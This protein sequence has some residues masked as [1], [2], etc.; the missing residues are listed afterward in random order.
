[1]AV[2]IIEPAILQDFF[3]SI[4]YVELKISSSAF[5]ASR[6]TIFLQHANFFSLI[7]FDYKGHFYHCCTSQNP[8]SHKKFTPLLGNSQTMSFTISG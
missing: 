3:C 5:A 4:N 6:N 1:M 8:V 7:S 2:A